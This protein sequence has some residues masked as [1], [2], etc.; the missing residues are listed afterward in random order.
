MA[1]KTLLILLGTLLALSLVS[2]IGLSVKNKESNQ[3]IKSASNTLFIVS[4]IILTMLVLLGSLCFIGKSHGMYE[5]NLSVP[6]LITGITHTPKEDT[7]PNNFKNTCI[8]YYRFTCDDCEAIYNDLRTTFLGYDNIYWISTR[9]DQGK[10]LTE[11]Y[12]VTQV[13]SAVYIDNNGIGH[14]Y[15]LAKRTNEKTHLDTTVIDRIH[16]LMQLNQE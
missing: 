10:K 8:I 3:A 9:S 4:G 15:L 14:T 5:Y 6:D 1:V 12:P 2:A 11:K 7:A 13:P 16:E